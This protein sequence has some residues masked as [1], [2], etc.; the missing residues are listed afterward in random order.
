MGYIIFFGVMFIMWG[1]IYKYLHVEYGPT[2]LHIMIGI[3]MILS[4]IGLI[5]STNTHTYKNT[6]NTNKKIEY[7]KPD[8]K[9]LKESDEYIRLLIDNEHV[10][11][12]TEHKYY[13]TENIYWQVESYKDETNKFI[14]YKKSVKK[15]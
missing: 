10:R 9:I 14:V 4:F 15:D 2:K 6:Y 8:I 1:S 3:F 11:T 7:I 13:K 12:Y 5:K